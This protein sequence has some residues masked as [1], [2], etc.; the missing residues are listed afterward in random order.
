MMIPFLE[1]KKKKEQPFSHSFK[2]S[3][4]KPLV[5]TVSASPFPAGIPK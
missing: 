1:Q 5:N 2:A 4:V 3:I